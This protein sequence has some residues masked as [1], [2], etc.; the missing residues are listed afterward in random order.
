MILSTIMLQ[1][2]NR[3]EVIEKSYHRLLEYC[4]S[5][6]DTA[7]RLLSSG[8]ILTVHP[9][10]SYLMGDSTRSQSGGNFYL[11]N[12]VYKELNNITVITLSTVIK[13]FIYFASEVGISEMFYNSKEVVLLCITLM[14]MVHPQPQT[15]VAVYNSMSHWFAMGVIVHKKSKATNMI[16]HFLKCSLR[17]HWVSCSSSIYVY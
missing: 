4:A 11:T 17:I 9:D 13:Y 14:K 12:Q 7:S 3:T 5:H 16:F 6:N 1:K 2:S 10:T 8:M 15:E